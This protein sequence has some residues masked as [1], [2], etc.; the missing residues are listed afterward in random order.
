MLRVDCMFFFFTTGASILSFRN[1]PHLWLCGLQSYQRFSLWFR[2]WKKIQFPSLFL[3]FCLSVFYFFVGFSTQFRANIFIMPFTQR[4][5]YK[6]YTYHVT[7]SGEPF[8]FKSLGRSM[9]AS[10]IA[11]SLIRYNYCKLCLNSISIYLP[12]FHF[13]HNT[14]TSI[15]NVRWKYTRMP[16][17]RS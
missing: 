13:H 8:H 16:L 3:S 4:I 11:Q 10:E 5:A 14:D 2:L 15:T 1:E 9:Y 7:D 17:N 12:W 6:N